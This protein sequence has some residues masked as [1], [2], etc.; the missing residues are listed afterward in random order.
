MTNDNDSQTTRPQPPDVSAEER[1]SAA[2]RE[3]LAPL[4]FE[5]SPEEG[6][7]LDAARRSAVA[8]AEARLNKPR[9]MLLR[10]QSAA[11]VAAFAVVAV[12]LVP[13]RAAVSVDALPTLDSSEFAAAAELEL[14]EDL[15][16]LAWLDEQDLADAG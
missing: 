3:R 16:L 8:A 10:W 14:L 9:M 4:E 15:E 2:L 5:I 7:R 12:I 6:A 11:A 13:Q 1:F